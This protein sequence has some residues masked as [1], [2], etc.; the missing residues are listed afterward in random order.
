MPDP[1]AFPFAALVGQSEMK[2]AL[3]LSVINPAVGGVLL[4]GPRGTGKTTAARAL[5]HLM[6]TVQRSRCQ[7]GCEPEMAFGGGPDAVC[8][9][10]AKK[11][12]RGEALT[13]P[14]VMRFVELPLSAG[15]S[16]VV[17]R[18]N[19]VAL[20]RGNFRLEQG[21]LSAANKSLLYVDE[22]NLLDAPI[23]DVILDAAAQGRYT[24]RR[25]PVAGTFQARFILVGSMNPEEGALRPQ[26]MDRFGLRVIVDALTES[27]D[28]LAL[29]ER[30]RAFRQDPSGF[31]RHWERETLLL[32]QEIVDARE[33]LPAIELSADAGQLGIHLVQK[34]AIASHRAEFT[35]F[36]AARARAAADGRAEAGPDD[37][38]AVAPMA[39]RL[40][41][42]AFM[43]RFGAEMT[44]EDTE[45]HAVLGESV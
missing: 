34:L 4:I 21:I 38:R 5:V 33:R 27:T 37:V 44:R 39:L 10:C 11:L 19:E 31:A 42:S 32:T 23:V 17:G 22:V 26:I 35:M 29:Y 8:E 18:V 25:G 20:E 28:R 12:A 6:P 7:W 1:V 16:D 3:L 43:E 9:E 24:V 14:D 36:E 13:Y 41:R 15:L 30:V 40:R 45:I 2:T